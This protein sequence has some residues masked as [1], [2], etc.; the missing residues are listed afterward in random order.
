[1]AN[2]RLLRGRDGGAVPFGQPNEEREAT[3]SAVTK[4]SRVPANCDRDPNVRR[5]GAADHSAISGRRLISESYRD[6]TDGCVIVLALGLGLA[7]YAIAALSYQF[8]EKP[9]LRLKARFAPPKNNA[10]ECL[11]CRRPVLAA[12]S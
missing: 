11:P 5:T 4:R 6:G 12:A 7:S 3:L 1:M 9:A 2:L 10:T 8:V